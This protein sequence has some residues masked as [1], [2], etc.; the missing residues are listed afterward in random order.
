MS[1]ASLLKM[2]PWGEIAKA[3]SRVPDL[4]RGMRGASPDAAPATSTP[5]PDAEHLMAEIIRIDGNVGQLRTYSEQ[6]A[7]AVATAMLGLSARV[8]RLT[9]LA[10]AALLAA[11]AAI[12]IPLV[13]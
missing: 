5:V 2:A 7:A 9:W 3:A 8:T 13:R 10:A 4:V 1:W 6:Q 11:I 12:V